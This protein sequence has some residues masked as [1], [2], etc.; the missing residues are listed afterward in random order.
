MTNINSYG[1]LVVLSAVL[2]TPPLA[3]AKDSSKTTQFV[4]NASIGGTFE[5]E[6]SQLA[7]ER[8][9][10][11]DVKSFAQMMVDDHTKAGDELKAAAA[12]EKV[13]SALTDKLDAKHQ[14]VLDK[15][16]KASDKDFD[17]D[18]ISAQKD[19]HKEAISLFSG[20]AKNGSDEALKG[21]AG[22]T[23]PT[24]KKHD[25]AVKNLKASS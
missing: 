13:D 24:L 18:Y 21:W 14:A 5:V 1:S 22:D 11:T 4:H 16:K 12:Q 19:A 15:L 8:S 7:L 17:K 6:S 3:V 2:L 23:L 9:Q 20:Y 10:N 25:D